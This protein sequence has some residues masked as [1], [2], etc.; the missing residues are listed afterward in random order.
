MQCTYLIYTQDI[1]T[2]TVTFLVCCNKTILMVHIIIAFM[3]VYAFIYSLDPRN[4]FNFPI[5]WIKGLGLDTVE[6]DSHK[7]YIVEFCDKVLGFLKDKILQAMET[8]TLSLKVMDGLYQE[9]LWHTHYASSKLKNYFVSCLYN[10][11]YKYHICLYRD[12]ERSFC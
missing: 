10:E 9:V 6:D 7:G 11:P 4:I 5:N 3:Y 8:T 12:K 1:D 2:H